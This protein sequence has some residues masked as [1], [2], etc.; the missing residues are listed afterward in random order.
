MMNPI[1]LLNRMNIMFIT[2]ES[3]KK[4]DPQGL[5]LNLL[6]KVKLRRKL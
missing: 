6:D 3:S 2:S 4:C 5:L 1:K